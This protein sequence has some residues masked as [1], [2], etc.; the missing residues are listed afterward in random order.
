MHLQ[1]ASRHSFLARLGK[2]K[3]EREAVEIRK[4]EKEGGGEEMVRPESAESS[5]VVKL[6][7]RRVDN[8]FTESR[9][10]GLSGWRK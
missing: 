8:L 5:F 4:S 1:S 7:S 2:G 9:T 10:A 6:E 3:R